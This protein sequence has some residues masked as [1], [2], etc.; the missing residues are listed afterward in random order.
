[1]KK[2]SKKSIKDNYRIFRVDENVMEHGLPKKITMMRITAENDDDAYHQLKDYIKYANREYK[3]FVEEWQPTII[4]RDGE[5]H[6]YEDYAD[7]MEKERKA[8]SFLRKIYDFVDKLVYRLFVSIPA[9]FFHKIKETIY[10][11]KHK[12]QLHASWCID[13]IMLDTLLF[14]IPILKKNKHCLSWKMLEKAILEKHPDFTKQDLEKYFATHYNGYGDD[15]EKR[16]VVLEKEMF[17]KLIDDIKAY[18]YYAG[19][20]AYIDKNDK[21]LAETDKKLR[22]TLPLIKG[23]YDRYEYKKIRDLTD[24]YW[25]KIWETV[26]TYGQEFND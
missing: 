1:M 25:N 26:R 20:Y 7:M 11:L 12:Q 4:I 3:Y 21:D 15:I 18:R 5:K 8:K 13:D 6:V 9:D 14:N 23:S 24:K 17:D 10:L 22:H 19:Q 2:H 16:A